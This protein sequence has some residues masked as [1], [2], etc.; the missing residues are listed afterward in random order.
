MGVIGSVGVPPRAVIVARQPVGVVQPPTAAVRPPVLMSALPPRAPKENVSPG[1]MMREVVAKIAG[2][3][4]PTTNGI[5]MTG[6][7]QTMLDRIGGTA[8]IPSAASSG[9][10]GEMA[11]KRVGAGTGGL[12]ANTLARAGHPAPP[13]ARVFMSPTF[14]GTHE[15]LI[16]WLFSGAMARSMPGRS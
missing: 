5:V 16:S 4:D 8:P 9:E 12:R 6:T 13:K 3:A 14:L 11:P 15:V 1:A 2:E 7:A 10:M